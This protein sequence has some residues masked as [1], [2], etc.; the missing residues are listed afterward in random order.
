MGL[1]TVFLFGFLSLMMSAVISQAQEI[2]TA[3]PDLKLR[4]KEIPG[5]DI[6]RKQLSTVVAGKEYPIDRLIVGIGVA[7]LDSYG[8]EAGHPAW[9]LDAKREFLYY[10]ALTGCGFESDGMVIFRTDLYGKRIEPVLGRCNNLK[11]EPLALVGKDYLLIREG[12]SGI[13]D[14]GFWIIDL[15]SNQP[16]LHAAGTLEKSKDG[17]F[18]YCRGNQEDP[19]LCKEVTADILL[20][21]KAPLELQ[22]RFPLKARSNQEQVPV[23]ISDGPSSCGLIP[24]TKV[25]NLPRKDALVAILDS[26]KDRGVYEIYYRGLRGTVSKNYLTGYQVD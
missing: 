10:T 9:Y 14:T 3:R 6:Q 5:T 17:G 7:R 24:A 15:E 20:N 13:G 23:R 12:D 4:L 8:P 1:R 11:M 16:A 25:E 26:C 21:R 19:G 2:P 18:K 22:P